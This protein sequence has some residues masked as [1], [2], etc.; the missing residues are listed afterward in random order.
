[1]GI[2]AIGLTGYFVLTAGAMALM[3]IGN[4]LIAGIAFLAIMVNS[5][6]LQVAGYSSIPE[7][8]PPNVRYT[9]TALGWNIGVVIAG[10]TAPVVCAWLVERTGIALSPALFVMTLSLVGAVAVLSVARTH[11]RRR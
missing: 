7:L 8:F 11:S 4:L 10:G 3:G 2:A 6:F 9:G 5:S 1:M